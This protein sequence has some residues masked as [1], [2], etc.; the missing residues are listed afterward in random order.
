M[1][2]G[3]IEL[4]APPGVPEGLEATAAWVGHQVWLAR[5]LF[6]VVGG[7]SIDEGDDEVRV[8]FATASRRHAGHAE[9]L[10]DLLPDTVEHD[11][12]QFVVPPSTGWPVV[13]DDLAAADDTVV[14]L[15]GHSRV[16]LTHLTLEHDAVVEATTGAAGGPIRR[17]LDLV[18]RDERD[19]QDAG[20]LLLERVLRERGPD[21]VRSA[22]DEQRA[23]ET[24][25]LLPLADPLA[26]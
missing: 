11:P 7:W 4:P 23:L 13:L 8:H 25:L 19:A 5:R 6:E 10:Y 9:I 12:D 14:R 22:T 3:S 18:G 21:A 2:D 20:E 16:V 1:E 26:P 15:A 17:A 24:T